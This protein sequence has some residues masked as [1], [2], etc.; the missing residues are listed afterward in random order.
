VNNDRDLPQFWLNHGEKLVSFMV[1]DD[2]RFTWG[3]AAC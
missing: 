1:Q 3:E 2:A